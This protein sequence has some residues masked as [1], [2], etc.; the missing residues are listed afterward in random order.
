MYETQKQKQ[1]L[2][3]VCLWIVTFRLVVLSSTHPPTHPLY[4]AWVSSGTASLVTCPLN[5]A[6]LRSWTSGDKYP[7][8]S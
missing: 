8:R 1:Q 2:S 6:L 7:R 4:S 3:L 5:N